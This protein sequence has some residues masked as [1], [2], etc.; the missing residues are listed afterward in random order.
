[1]LASEQPQAAAAYDQAYNCQTFIGQSTC[2][3]AAGSWYTITNV[4][5]S[6][7][8]VNDDICA[9]YGNLSYTLTCA[10]SG[11]TILLCRSAVYE[12]GISET[13][14]GHNDNISGHEDNDSS[15]D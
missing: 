3:L 15:C 1:M 11:Y 8:T 6:N 14:D 4:G 9:Q 5:A 13:A 7:Y 12:Y 10:T 2:H